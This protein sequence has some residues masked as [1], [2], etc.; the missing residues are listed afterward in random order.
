MSSL[1]S[2]ELLP[3][4]K[5]AVKSIYKELGNSYNKHATIINLI[6]HMA[7][8]ERHFGNDVVKIFIKKG[9]LRKHR[10]NTFCWTEKGLRY[11]VN[12][13]VKYELKEDL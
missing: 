10:T 13:L 9:L 3:Q 8:N 4:Y 1:K 6:R 7:K 5:K 12:L 11:C 2:F